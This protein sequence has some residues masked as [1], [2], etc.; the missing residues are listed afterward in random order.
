M[1]VLPKT[2]GADKVGSIQGGTPQKSKGVG[3]GTVGVRI[4]RLRWFAPTSKSQ[5]LTIRRQGRDTRL[6]ESADE[7]VETLSGLFGLDVPEVGDL[8]PRIVARHEVFVRELQ[9]DQKPR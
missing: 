4:V 2:T 8:W 3:R 5:P 1:G 7:L 9:R 6:I